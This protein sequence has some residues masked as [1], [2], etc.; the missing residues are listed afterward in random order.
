MN[1]HINQKSN[2]AISIVAILLA[3]IPFAPG[4]QQSPANESIPL[5]QF[6]NVPLNS[7][8]ETLGKQ[9]DMNC[10]LDPRVSSRRYVTVKWE[11]ISAMD[12]LDRVLKQHGLCLIDNPTTTVSRIAPTN[13]L[14]HFVDKGW[15]KADTNSAVPL[16]L[17]EDVTLDD[18]I[19]E[20][21]AKAGL[22]VELDPR[23]SKYYVAPGEHF[24][25]R[26][27]LSVRFQ[28]LRPRQAIAA[29]CENYE[30]AVNANA[31]SSFFQIAPIERPDSQSAKSGQD[32]AAEKAK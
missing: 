19:N 31:G 12:A 24:A 20:L 15:I 22:K 7:A 30:L 5:I 29:L 17:F 8:I 4:Q 18:A 2:W 25:S 10:I 26:V 23:L 16:I 6:E 32:K 14:A 1:T 21:S 3:A 13:V 28:N 9:A 27:T 11:N